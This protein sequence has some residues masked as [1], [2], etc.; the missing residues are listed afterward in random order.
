MRTGN[1]PLPN[2]IYEYIYDCDYLF[3]LLLSP[4]IVK[5][6]SKTLLGNRV[7]FARPF[8]F[9]KSEGL[10]RKLTRGYFFSQLVGHGTKVLDAFSLPLLFKFFL[11]QH[12]PF[13]L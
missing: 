8:N 11:L 6:R 7:F 9:S 12:S 2:A 3:L 4:S 10:R 1:P 5:V 13:L